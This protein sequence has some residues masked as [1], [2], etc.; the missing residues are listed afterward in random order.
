MSCLIPVT[1]VPVSALR[2]R[3]DFPGGLDQARAARRFAAALLADCPQLDE[4]LLAVDELV[5]NALRHTK[6]GQP[7]GVFGVEVIRWD[8]A[9]AVSVTDE[10][11]P[12][13]PAVTDVEEYAESGRGL[14]TV[15]LLAAGW[16]W[17]GNDRSRTVAALFDTTLGAVA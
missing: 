1:S 11:A 9:V 15:S 4:V 14:R 3:R 10:G 2:W 16:G 13:E 17:F 5:V 7:G 12:S 6:S 8:G